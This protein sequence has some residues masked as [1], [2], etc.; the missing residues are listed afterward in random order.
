MKPIDFWFDFISPFGYLAS[1]R[2]DALAARHGREV[3]WHPMLIGVTV[4]KVMGLRPV[5]STPLKGD[6]IRREIARYQRRHGIALARDIDAAPMNPLPAGRMFAWL[7]EHAPGHAK[8]FARAAYDAY[9]ARAIDIDSADSLG[10][11]GLRSGLSAALIERALVADAEAAKD[12]LR[13]EVDDAI[14]RGAFGS[15]F[16]IVDGEPFF[17]LDK[18]ELID[19]WLARGGW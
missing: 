14:A 12:L 5:L 9:W 17:G 8:P 16:F 2:I 3:R 10:D 7:L 1:L 18:L 13:R 11:C 15:P 6:Y 19:D 4:L